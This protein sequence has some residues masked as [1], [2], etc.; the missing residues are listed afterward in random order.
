MDFK[1]RRVIVTGASTGIGKELALALAKKGARLTLAA[2]SGDALL[3]LARDCAGAGGEALVVPTDVTIPDACRALVEKTA[4]RFGGVDCLVNNA[5]L[6]IRARFED[7]TDLTVYERIMRVNYLG[8]VY[9]THYALPYLKNS[10][11]LLVA[12]SSLTGLM[13]VPTRTAYAASKHA[14][15]GFFDSLRIELAGSGVD[16]LVVSPG[17]VATGIRERALGPDGKPLGQTPGSD[18][19]GD[20]STEECVRRIVL[21]MEARQRELVMM[22]RSTLTRMLQVLAPK[23]VDQRIAEA[24]RKRDVES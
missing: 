19:S 24:I 22:P 12:I 15:Q 13:G 9:C 20:M 11:G 6:A 2:R 16:V 23:Q 17:F 3:E 14:I 21:A 7:T 8:T 1:A 10:R 18:H 4:E 5:G